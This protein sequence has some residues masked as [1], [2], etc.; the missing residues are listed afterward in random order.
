[1]NSI[2]IVTQTNKMQE[3]SPQESAKDA[4]NFLPQTAQES[5][6]LRCTGGCN[7]GWDDKGPLWAGTPYDKFSWELTQPDKKIAQ[8]SSLLIGCQMYTICVPPG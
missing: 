2:L 8:N 4:R 6:V 7:E 1:M 3:A 5:K